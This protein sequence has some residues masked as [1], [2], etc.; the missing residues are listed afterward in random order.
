[1]M[2]NQAKSIPKTM[3]NQHKIDAGKRYAKM[4]KNGAKM[5]PKIDPK[6]VCRVFRAVKNEVQKS[7]RNLTDFQEISKT[8]KSPKQPTNQ[9]DYLSGN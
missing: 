1:M 4:T 3:K 2:N 5:G 7:I 9:Q 6:S 8:A